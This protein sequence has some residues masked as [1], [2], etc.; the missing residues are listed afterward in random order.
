MK[1]SKHSKRGIDL[2]V[3]A[4]MTHSRA[5]ELARRHYYKS[6]DLGGAPDPELE[7]KVE[8]K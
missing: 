8:A 4:V 6:V 1:E 2:A 3:A 5:V 7:K